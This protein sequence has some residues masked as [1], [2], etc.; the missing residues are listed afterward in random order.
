MYVK[1]NGD[2]AGVYP[3]ASTNNGAFA[4]PDEISL[5]FGGRIA[6]SDMIKIGFMN[7]NNMAASPMV[8]GFKLPIVIDLGAAKVMA[9]PFM[10]DGLG[11]AYGYEESSTGLSRGVRWGENRKEISAANYV[12]VGTAA[13]GFSFVLKN[14]M[15]YVNVTKWGPLFT[16]GTGATSRPT[17]TWLRVAA[18]PTIADWAMHIGVGVASGTSQ[19]VAGGGYAGDRESNMTVVDF[20]GQGEIAAMPTSVYVQTAT[21]PKSEAGKRANLFNGNSTDTKATTIGADVSVVPNVLHFGFA[22][23]NAKK[24]DLSDNA[25]TVMAVYDLFQNVG[26]HIEHSMFSGD[27][28]SGTPANGK[29]KTTFLLEA[30][31]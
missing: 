26:V 7:E 1:T 19:S 15:G 16:M 21:A 25:T 18:T 22:L 11:M 8:A 28:Y 2:A 5:F 9:I 31:W 3:G 4:I 30:A 29:T 10:T 20:Q 17:S 14:D 12:G 23:R 27:T 13:S 24:N 6:D